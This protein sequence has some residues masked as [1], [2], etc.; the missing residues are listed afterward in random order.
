MNRF[1][2]TNSSWLSLLGLAVVIVLLAFIF[3]PKTLNY[4]LNNYETLKLVND[5]VVE[6]T[7]D[8]LGGKQLIDIRSAE[9]FLNGHPV[10]AVSI[11]TRQLLDKESL[12]MFD[13]L[14]AANKD[15]V[16]YGTNELD[17]AAPLFLLRQLGYKN[18]KLIKGRLNQAN[19][20]ITSLPGSTEV[21]VLDTAALHHKSEQL[22]TPVV[23]SSRKKGE[24]II[25]V[26]KSASA[27][28]GC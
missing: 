24:A 20:F 26:R 2:K 23:T 8:H 7:T 21:Q 1:I 25:P 6:V 28:G 13:D 4:Q 19:E 15:A 27:G 18:V 16:L 5:P 10:G 22:I 14:L 11:P 17:A 9:L 12:K 3:R